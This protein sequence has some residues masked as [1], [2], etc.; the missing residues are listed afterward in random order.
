MYKLEYFL[1]VNRSN[2]A[3]GVGYKY[4]VSTSLTLCK[5]GQTQS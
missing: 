5:V 1:E 3:R 2:T 4:Q